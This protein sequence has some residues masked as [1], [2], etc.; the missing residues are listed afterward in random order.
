VNDSAKTLESIEMSPLPALFISHGAPDLPIRDGAVT[1]FL[2][3]LHQQ[4]PQPKAILVISAHWNS[5]TPMVSKATKPQTIYDF[6][7]FPDAVY[8]LKYP[9]PGA[10]VL[11]DR[12]KGVRLHHSYNYGAFSM[13]AYGFSGSV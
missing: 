12:V 1:H 3:S 6:G 2:R 11:A 5:A 4:F 10:P 8:Q 9:A 13:A 7:G